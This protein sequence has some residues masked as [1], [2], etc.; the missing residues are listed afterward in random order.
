M[1]IEP[2]MSVAQLAKTWGV[3]R[4][5][6]YNLIEA[7][8]LRV[9]RVG[10]LIRIRP[11][12]LEEYERRQCQDREPNSPPSPSPGAVAGITSSGGRMAPHAGFHAARKTLPKHAGS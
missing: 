5:T 8:A 1:K 2:R 11:D 6:I 4:Q 7:G 9:V 3:S 10:K 12:D